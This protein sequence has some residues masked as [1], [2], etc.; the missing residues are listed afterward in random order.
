MFELT[1]LAGTLRDTCAP[2]GAAP[3]VCDAWDVRVTDAHG[4][5][6]PLGG[7]GR[8]RR[9]ALPLVASQRFLDDAPFHAEFGRADGAVA[10][11]AYPPST[12]PET[13][14]LRKS[15]VGALQVVQPPGGW[16]AV[17]RHAGPLQ[18]RAR[19]VDETGAYAALYTARP[20]GSG[21]VEV[22][23]V[24]MGGG[25]GPQGGGGGV[26]AAPLRYVDASRAHR[27]L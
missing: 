14:L 26:A 25:H 5:A 10:R 24:R 6:R 18:W 20:A 9:S 3:D 15:F 22:T 23:K 7:D 19:E 2:G 16:A 4:L 11:V 13:A 17:A 27:F 12:P 21:L 8:W 1:A